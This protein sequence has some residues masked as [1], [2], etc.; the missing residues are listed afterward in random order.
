M[1]IE[2]PPNTTKYYKIFFS[3]FSVSNVIS[4]ISQSLQTSRNF[5]VKIPIEYWSIFTLSLMLL[6][7][8]L[9]WIL[10][11]VI[12]RLITQNKKKER[13]NKHRLTYMARSLSFQK[14][15]SL[16]ISGESPMSGGRDREFLGLLQRAK[17]NSC[18]IIIRFLSPKAKPP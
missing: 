6:M 14:Q 8:A 15:F 13:K 17:L 18:D 5:S 10:Y 4:V 16:R 1:R 9:R 12:S 11:F 2:N 7:Y 3:I